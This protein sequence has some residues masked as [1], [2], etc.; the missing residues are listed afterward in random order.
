M[1]EV[2]TPLVMLLRRKGPHR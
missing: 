2:F 1:F